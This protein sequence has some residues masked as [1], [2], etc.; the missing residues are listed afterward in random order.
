MYHYVLSSTIL[1]EFI[2]FHAPLT[3]PPGENTPLYHPCYAP[4]LALL[5]SNIKI[6]SQELSYEWHCW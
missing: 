2:E 3:T 1:F 6:Y 4:A 5:P